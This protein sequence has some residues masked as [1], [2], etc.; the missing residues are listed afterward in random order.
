MVVVAM[1]HFC[2]FS[3]SVLTTDC[4]REQLSLLKLHQRDGARV[5][6]VSKGLPAVV[7]HQVLMD[8]YVQDVATPMRFVADFPSELCF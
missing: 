4:Q 2:S 8:M 3:L 7:R 1:N 5:R 6:N